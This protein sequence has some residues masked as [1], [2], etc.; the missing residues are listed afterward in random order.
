MENFDYCA[1]NWDTK[2][3]IERA[4]AIANEICM[5]FETNSKKKSAMEFG[6]GTGLVGVQLIDS[7][8]AITFVD[9]S[10]GMIE[11]VKKKLSELSIRSASALC[12]DFMTTIPSD[13]Q[14]DYIFSS[15]VLHHIIDTKTILTRLHRLLNSGGHLLLVD[16]D[17]DD[18]SFHAK[19]PDFNGHN[20]FE[21]LSLVNLSREVGFSKVNINTF[22]RDS[23]VF[24]GKEHPY[25]LFILDAVK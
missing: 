22:Y 16:L 17:I 19:Y 20:G 6:C 24:N 14:V 12:C 9:S 11:Q 4:K 23:K 7:F 25:S 18:G 10:A 2:N 21:Q 1:K 3:R 15:L 8:E 5:H 13:L